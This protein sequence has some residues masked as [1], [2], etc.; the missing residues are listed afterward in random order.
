MIE[1]RLLRNALMLAKHQNFAR[2]AKEL[3]ISQPTLTRSIQLLEKTVGDLLFDRTSRTILPTKTGEI[4]LKHASIIIASTR[5]MRDEVSLYKGLSIGSLFIGA[6]PY[7]GTEL[8]AHATSQFSRHYPGIKIEIRIGDWRKLPGRWTQEGFDFL[9][10]ETSKLNESPDFEITRLNHHQGFFF[11]RQNHPLLKKDNLAISELQP[12]PLIGPALPT[13]L[14]NLFSGLSVSDG[15]ASALPIIVPTY[16]CNDLGTIKTIV[17]ESDAIGLGT[18]GI[19]E[20]ELE[21]GLFKTLPF[22]MPALK[23]DHHIVMRKGLSLS[24]SAKAFIEFLIIRDNELSIL[25]ADLIKSLG[26]AITG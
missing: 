24:P 13:R 26:P 19:L 15:D 3:H 4:V 1:T 20:Q 7:A 14:K 22:Y 16:T 10:M 11:C 5:A 21:S 18:F 25:E 9:V 6:G 17:R 23:T 8:L 2:A 12:F